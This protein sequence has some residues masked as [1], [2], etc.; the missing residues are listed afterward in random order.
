[1]DQLAAQQDGILT[2]IIGEFR[3]TLNAPVEAGD[4]FFALGGTSFLAAALATRLTSAFSRT[5][6]LAAIL[7]NPSPEE[8]ASY[9]RGAEPVRAE[10]VSTESG[11][12]E[13]LRTVATAALVCPAIHR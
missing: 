13:H 5:V 4:N 3:A 7:R 11:R 9:L 8:L 10:P 6:N 12:S 1:M 2:R